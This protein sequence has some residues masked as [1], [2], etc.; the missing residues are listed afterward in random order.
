MT[1]QALFTC[2]SCGNTET[3]AAYIG[4]V[5]VNLPKDWY[6]QELFVRAYCLESKKVLCP[7][8]GH[9]AK[10]L[11][12]TVLAPNIGASIEIPVSELLKSYPRLDQCMPTEDD[13]Q[14]EAGAQ[15]SLDSA[16]EVECP[17]YRDELLEIKQ[18]ASHNPLFEVTC[19]HCDETF[20]EPR[21]PRGETKIDAEPT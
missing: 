19:P 7:K 9:K 13:G 3:K 16:I 18:Q 11:V 20:L 21:N 2:D 14:E 12:R 1:I 4:D 17:E 5:T 8:C 10:N 15:A 6:I